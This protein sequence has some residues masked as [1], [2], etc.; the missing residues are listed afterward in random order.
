MVVIVTTEPTPGRSTSTDCRTERPA[1]VETIKTLVAVVEES[2]GSIA[3]TE[4]LSGA[5]SEW[6]TLARRV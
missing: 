6:G 3:V 1:L 4:A 2:S 5:L